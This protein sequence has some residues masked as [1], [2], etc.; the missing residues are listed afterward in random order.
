M[1][2]SGDHGIELVGPRTVGNVVRGNTVRRNGRSGVALLNGASRNRIGGPA[3][4]DAN[5]ISGNTVFGVE[6]S[7]PKGSPV[8]PAGD[9][10]VE[11]NFIGT[12]ASGPRPTGSGY[13]SRAGNA[14]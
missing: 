2:N 3:A 12:K 9:D 11:G 7:T 10:V 6:I 1:E 8:G 5:V 14:R 4:A 13:W